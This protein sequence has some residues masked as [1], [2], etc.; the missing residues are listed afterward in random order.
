ME[1]RIEDVFALY[2]WGVNRAYRTRGAWILET[3]KGLRLLKS[4]DG[5]TKHLEFEH[6]VKEYLYENGFPLTDRFEKNKEQQL[7]S[8]DTTGKQYIVKEWIS[9]EECN[10]KELRQVKEASE[11]LALLHK[12]MRNTGLEEKRGYPE[13]KKL[14]FIFQKHNR[15][16]KRVFSYVK[17][18]KQKNE[19]EVYF[20]SC[21][22]E[23]YV[24]ATKALDI[25]NASEYEKRMAQCIEEQH[26]CHGSYNY[27][28]ILMTK[29]GIFTTNF[30][31]AEIGLQVMDLYGFFRK[32]MEKNSWK[33]SYAKTI[34]ESYRKI[35]PLSEEEWKLFYILV[36]YPEKFWKVTNFYYNSKKSWISQRNIQKLVNIK[37]QMEQKNILLSEI[38]NFTNLS[39]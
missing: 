16:L 6:E 23:F 31:R 19:F 4:F 33:L 39:L 38:R 15:E 29:K 36:L 28:N 37:E 32:V 22:Q 2:D 5:K 35:M 21:F 30:E 10:L 26:I 14:P 7:I 9:G 18:K 12:K 13:E 1:E 24:Q 20:L 8:Q 34:L 17:E 3:T 27:H 11:N 25:L